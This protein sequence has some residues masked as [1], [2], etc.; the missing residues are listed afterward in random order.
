M[1]YLEFYQ[2][3]WSLQ[4]PFSRPPLFARA[5][6]FESFRKGVDTVLPVISEAT[7][8][9]RAMM[10]SKAVGGGL[11]RKRDEP[12]GNGN[13]N[14]GGTNSSGWGGDYFAKF[15]TSPELLDL[16]VR[17][18]HSVTSVYSTRSS[19]CRYQLPSPVPLS[20]LDTS[21]TSFAVHSY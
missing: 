8:K 21:T 17:T 13:G 10:G 18:K 7:K 14:G 2:T 6:P 3:F 19:D 20:T 4:I 9:E 11:K 5:L 12:E 15:L 16:E 1:L